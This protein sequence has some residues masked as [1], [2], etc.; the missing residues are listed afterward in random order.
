MFT[1]KKRGKNRD[2]RATRASE[3]FKKTIHTGAVLSLA[4]HQRT[5]LLLK[6]YI[7]R[8]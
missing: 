4:P 1:A 6:P 5:S 7:L 2:Y 3:N 8:S